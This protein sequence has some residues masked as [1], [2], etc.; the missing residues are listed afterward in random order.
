MDAGG[1]RPPLPLFD[2]AYANFEFA[3]PSLSLPEAL[4]VDLGPAEPILT[5]SGNERPASESEEDGDGPRRGRQRKMHPCSMCHK[6]FDRP[7]TLRVHQRVHTLQKDYACDK[8]GKRFSVP[9]NTKRHAKKCGTA[10]AAPASEPG[11]DGS[12]TPSPGSEPSAPEPKAKRPRRKKAEPRWVPE[13]LKGFVIGCTWKAPR[14]LPPITP[15]QIS[16]TEWEERDSFAVGVPEDPYCDRYWTGRLPGPALK[17]V[18]LGSSVRFA[19]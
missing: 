6:S 8:C 3:A 14:P 17:D 1:G 15:H 2:Y 5:T 4:S 9:S 12:Q 10:A 19:S 13:T 7:S 16:A 11:G 18:F